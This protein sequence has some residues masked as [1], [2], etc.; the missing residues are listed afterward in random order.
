MK[1]KLVIAL[2]K[3]NDKKRYG[4]V[5]LNEFN[6]VNGIIILRKVINIYQMDE[7]SFISLTFK[8]L[9]ILNLRKYNLF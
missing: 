9:K 3:T 6:Q 4:Q 2:F 8:N 5:L 7:L 1:I